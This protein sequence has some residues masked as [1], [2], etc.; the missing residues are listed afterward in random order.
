MIGKSGDQSRPCK[1]GRA[2]AIAGPVPPHPHGRY[3]DQKNSVRNPPQSATLTSSTD[4]SEAF[5]ESNLPSLATMPIIA[6]NFVV[7]ESIFAHH[8]EAG[9]KSC[10]ALVTP[11][12]ISE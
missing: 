12:G 1:K 3:A 11:N 5:S 4:H 7:E 9:S 2:S 6:G 8:S 10:S